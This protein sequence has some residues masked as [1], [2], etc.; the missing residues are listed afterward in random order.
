MILI[1]II[2]LIGILFSGIFLLSL[3]SF[4]LTMYNEFKCFKRG[5][6]A[7]KMSI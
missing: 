3:T 6:N 7:K 5:Q 2:A 4:L 1:K